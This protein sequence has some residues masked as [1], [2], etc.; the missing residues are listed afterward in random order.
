MIVCVYHLQE[1]KFTRIVNIIMKGESVSHCP[2]YKKLT[3]FNVVNLF[4]TGIIQYV[5]YSVY[6]GNV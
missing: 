3:P 6:T 1:I 4:N 5:L 2:G